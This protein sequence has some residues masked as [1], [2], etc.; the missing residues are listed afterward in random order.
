MVFMLKRISIL[1]AAIL[2]IAQFCLQLNLAKTD[3]QTTDEAVHLFAGYLYFTQGNFR[4]NPEHPPLF[5]YLAA[6]PLLFIHPS[7][8]QSYAAY[9][10]KLS[11]FYFYGDGGL[12][13]TATDFL[14][15]SGNDTAKL[16]FWGRVPMILVTLALGIALFCI[17]VYFWGW[18]GGIIALSLYVTDPLVNGHGH[19]IENDIGVAL[20]V[21]VALFALWLFLKNSSWKKAVLFGVLLGA[22]E[23]MK[24]SAVLLF[25]IT[26][27]SLIAYA[28][29]FK[30]GWKEF[31]GRSGKILAAFVIAFAVILAGYQFKLT[32]PPPAASWNQAIMAANPNNGPQVP[33]NAL[34]NHFYTA[35]RFFAVPRDYYL[36]LLSFTNHADTGHS[37]FLLGKTSN[38]GW[39]YYFPIVFSAKTPVASML[40]MLGAV[41]L[42]FR[43]R[44]ETQAGL[45]IL[46]VAALY[47][48]FSC[49]SKVDI[50]LRHIMPVYPLMFVLSGIIG[51][52]IST[53]KQKNALIAT[54]VLLAI[55]F[56]QAIAMYPYYIS[57]FNELYGGIS[58]GY[59]IASDSNID[60]G[61]DAG[62]IKDYID[63]NHVQ[64]VWIDYWDPSILEYYKISYK[65]LWQFKKGDKGV[66]IIG[67]TSLEENTS[68]AWLKAYTSSARITPSVF[69]YTFN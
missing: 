23:L 69:V 33:D 42:A 36:G 29:Y 62:R 8:P 68:D 55:L 35:F 22:A 57:S 31:W 37:S 25:P 3:S 49:L 26:L 56:I 63:A 46:L 60:W 34:V 40:I 5:K 67:A 65:P 58:N 51:H 19:L 7:I 27:V 10:Q 52:E 20:A 15:H 53:K 39:H 18:L 21:L 9:N 44:K 2:L 64:N 6:A 45:S 14:Y 30:I 38:T 24:F 41:I 59:T 61:Q 28:F 17:A 48:A 43:K 32:P 4:Y 13:S 11:N 66:V 54:F 50:G 1:A 47:F 16:L 12:Q